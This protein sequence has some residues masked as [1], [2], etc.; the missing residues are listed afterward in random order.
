MPRASC[1]FTFQS[2]DDH[3]MVRCWLALSERYKY[4]MFIKNEKHKNQL[5][6]SAKPISKPKS[7][8]CKRFSRN[9]C[10]GKSYCYECTGNIY[11]GP[12]TNSKCSITN[13]PKSFTR[14]LRSLH[15]DWDGNC[16]M[17]MEAAKHHGVNPSE[18]Y[19]AVPWMK[20]RKIPLCIW[21]LGR[22]S[23]RSGY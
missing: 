13:L 10:N 12:A 17:C 6:K 16:T 1:S 14:S 22:I 3:R 7:S 11:R 20:S 8:F 19:Q 18:I 21:G 2:G 5:V 15:A 23:Q 9:M 4:S